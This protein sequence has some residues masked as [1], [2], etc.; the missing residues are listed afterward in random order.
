MRFNYG[1]YWYGDFWCKGLFKIN[2]NNPSEK[3][4]VKKA[5]RT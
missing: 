5:N 1:T 2:L 3:I 4:I